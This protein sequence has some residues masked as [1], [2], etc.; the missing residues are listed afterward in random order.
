M[1]GTSNGD[2]ELNS[3]FIQ[4]I[5]VF[6]F[7]GDLQIPRLLKKCDCEIF[8][9]VSFIGP[10]CDFCELRCR[11]LIDCG[12]VFIFF[13]FLIFVWCSFLD[14]KMILVFMYVFGVECVRRAA[15]SEQ[16]WNNISWSVWREAVE[17]KDWAF[18][19]LHLQREVSNP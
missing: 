3:T 10:D 2:P 8:Y 12:F 17:E 13:T 14:L 7:G 16:T 18:F 19:L 11:V 15:G 5:R 4:T 6:E 9:P 1:L